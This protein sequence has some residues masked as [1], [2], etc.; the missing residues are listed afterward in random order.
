MAEEW[1]LHNLE[2]AMHNFKCQYCDGQIRMFAEPYVTW[3]VH[4][5]T[6]RW[7]IHC[8]KR[9]DIAETKE[10]ALRMLEQDIRLR[11]MLEKEGK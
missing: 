6:F 2:M 9:M 10:S 1:M 5:V 8:W 3:V 11:M 7:H 4:K